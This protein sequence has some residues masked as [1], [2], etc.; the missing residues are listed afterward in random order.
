MN[1]KNSATCVQHFAQTPFLIS[2]WF[3]DQFQFGAFL[4]QVRRKPWPS[5]Y[6]LRYKKMKKGELLHTS[7]SK[8]TARSRHRNPRCHECLLDE[9]PGPTPQRNLNLCIPR[10]GIAR[11]QSQFSHSFL[12]LALLFSC[13]RIG[14]PIRGIYKSLT[15]TCYIYKLLVWL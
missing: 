3:C 13:I 4:D 14:R 9:R 1:E 12:C 15:E 11:P 6:R 7:I 2:V 5:H 8:I 10:K